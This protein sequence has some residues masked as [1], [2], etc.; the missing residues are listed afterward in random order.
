MQAERT[1]RCSKDSVRLHLALIRYLMFWTARSS[2]TTTVG[3][4]GACLRSRSSYRSKRGLTGLG[5]VTDSPF[6]VHATRFSGRAEEEVSEDL[7]TAK[8]RPLCDCTVPATPRY[9]PPA[10]TRHL[11]RSSPPSTA[12]PTTRAAPDSPARSSGPA[13]EADDTDGQDIARDL[14]TGGG[15]DPGGPRQPSLKWRA[16]PGECR[17]SFWSLWRKSAH[18]T[19][20]RRRP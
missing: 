6:N 17:S 3:M 16:F 2:N 15:L 11:S 18:G 9:M 12:H 10:K 7:M 5:I 4:I 14:R 19:G 1:V 8:Q 13:S 20:G